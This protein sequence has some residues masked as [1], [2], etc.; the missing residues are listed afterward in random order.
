MTVPDCIDFEEYCKKTGETLTSDFREAAEVMV[1]HAVKKNPKITA[2]EIA[3]MVVNCSL[4]A[5]DIHEEDEEYRQKMI[6]E[7]AGKISKKV[8][9]WKTIVTLAGILKEEYEREHGETKGDKELEKEIKDLEER[10]DKT[11]Y[12]TRVDFLRSNLDDLK[13]KLRK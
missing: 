11:P 4:N 1:E 5:I 6:K 9:Y 7:I 8:N 10:I 13:K 2:Q 3:E 12:P